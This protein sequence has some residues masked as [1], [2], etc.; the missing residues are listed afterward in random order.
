[1]FLWLHTFC[2]EHICHSTFGIRVSSYLIKLDLSFMTEMKFTKQISVHTGNC[3]VNYNGVVPILRYEDVLGSGSK[4]PWIFNFWSRCEVRVKF[5]TPAATSPEKDLSVPQPG[6]PQE[7]VW[8]W[9][10]KD[11]Y[12]KH[13][14]ASILEDQCPLHNLHGTATESELS[15]AGILN[16]KNKLCLV[17]AFCIMGINRV[18]LP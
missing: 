5:H 1:M 7:L 4:V 14:M 15:R 6:C 9:W 12:L 10:R 18:I 8:R 16:R 2:L 13:E 11:F 3:E 17:T